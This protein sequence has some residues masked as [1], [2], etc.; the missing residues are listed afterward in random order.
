MNWK[1][2]LYILL[3]IF[4]FACGS[5]DKNGLDDNFEI[6]GTIEGAG[7]K[8]LY[9][10]ALSS[11]GVIDVAQTKLE[12][13]GTF[14]L[15][16]NVPAMGIYQLRLGEGEQNILPMTLSPDEKISLE[17]SI[18]KYMR[19]PV[20]KGAVWTE[21]LNKYMA[22]FDDFANE[23]S[24]MAQQSNSMSQEEMMQ[25]YLTLRK[26]LDEFAKNQMRKEPANPV[27]IILMSSLTPS[28]GWEFWDPSNLEILNHVAAAFN[29]KYKGSPIA[30]DMAGQQQQLS[31]SY[32]QFLAYKESQTTGGTVPEIELPTPEGKML[33]LSS[34]RGKVVLID[35]WASWCGPCRRENPNV[36]K[37]YN[38]YKNKGFT[39]FSVSL[40]ENGEAWKK[41][42]AMDGL[43]WPNHVSDL[44]GWNT[45]MTQL[46]GFNAIPHTVLIDANGKVIATN[47]RGQDLEQKLKEIL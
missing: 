36:V 26:P 47:L 18:D 5:S 3:S 13:D 4:L 2:S 40:D 31:N 25:A 30:E 20:F 9:L 43:L 32:Q 19:R 11:N 14:E 33:K 6:T 17:V 27:N 37:M 22:L 45:P 15:V 21:P 29:E 42:I 12:D 38:Q 34:L 16:G 35:F 10:E 23:Q 28:M 1:N 7:G 39:V 8:T 46:Y 24:L 44:K 41:A